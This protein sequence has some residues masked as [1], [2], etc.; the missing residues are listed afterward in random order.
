MADAS[1][2]QTAAATVVAGVAGQMV[3]RRL[4]LPAILPLLLIGV[5]LGPSLAGIVRPAALGGEGLRTLIGFAVAI[6]LF[7][8]G[9]SLKTESFRLA[10]TVIR[11]L[12]LGGALVTWAIAALFARAFFPELGLGPAVLF[13]ALV[14]VTGPTVI[15]PLLQAVHPRRRVSDV[16]RGEAI[17][18][19]PVGA[20][21][22]VLVL[23]FLIEAEVHGSVHVLAAFGGRV[24]LGLGLG[25][26]GAW[27]LYVL[28]RRREIL[29]VDL[30]NLAVLSCAIGLF[31]VSELVLPESGVLTVTL[32]GFLLGWLHP[33]GLAEIEEFKGHLTTL[34]VSVVFVLLAA[35]LDLAGLAALGRPALG[36]V[37]AIVFV[38]RPACVALCTLGTRLS[39][40][41]RLF[42]SWIAPRGIVA[43]AVSSLFALALA[44]HGIPEGHLVKDLVFAVIAGTV[45]LQAPT[46]RL[47]GRLL[48]VLEEERHGFV[49]VGANSLALAVGRALHRAGELVVLLDTNAWRVER[50]RERGLRAH[51]ADAL[52]PLLLETLDLDGIGHLL[53]LTPNEGVNRA[54]LRVFSRDF[55]PDRVRAIRLEDSPAAPDDA[56]FLFGERLSWQEGTDLVR[57]GAVIEK[58]RVDQELTIDG[59]DQAH[60]GAIGLLALDPSGAP[61]LLGDGEDLE[62]GETLFYLAPTVEGAPAGKEEPPER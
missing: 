41:E 38:A 34:M 60:E 27:T 43:A 35:D 52:D 24:L 55:G 16:L 32:A 10:G 62:V 18:I 20:L 9:L 3:A 49:I 21:Y 45:L 47:V 22:A 28:I 7:E 61:R 30:R 59:L 17:L 13:G 1:L 4:R 29:P 26:V 36:L 53:A 46:A 56:P 54:A 2:V 44:E 42:L 15:L 39:V 5:A 51:R 58:A 50:A 8:G 40:S 6:I 57:A 23:E 37:A 25:A 14:I 19:D 48:G 12:V 33:P 31:A 11:N